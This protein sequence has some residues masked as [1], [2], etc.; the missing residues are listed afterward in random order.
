MARSAHPARRH[1][2][3]GAVAA[4][5]GIAAIGWVLAPNAVGFGSDHMAAHGV[6]E[7]A[8]QE[9]TPLRDGESLLPVSMARAYTPAKQNG[10]WDDYRCFILDPR[11]DADAWLTGTR[12]VPGNAAVVHHII[13]FQLDADRVAAAQEKDAAEPGAGWSCFGGPGLQVTT[14]PARSAFS[15]APW[16]AAWAPGGS[17]HVIPDG[18]GVRMAAGSRVI[19]QV[20]YNLRAGR[21]PD[22][23]RLELRTRPADHSMTALHT[24]LLAAPVELP[25]LPGEKGRLCDRSASIADTVKRF[26]YGALETISGLASVCR[27]TSPNPGPGQTQSCVWG[28][29]EDMIVYAAAPHMHLLGS[30]MTIESNPGTPRAQTLL[31]VPRY[32]FDRQGA[33]WLAQ[34]VLL[35]AGDALRITCTW[36]TALRRLL[37]AFAG[38]KPRY[39]TWGEGTTDEMCLGVLSASTVPAPSPAS[40]PR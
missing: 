8:A 34:P 2:A 39:V 24:R 3:V 7:Q 25:C 38:V 28:V 11:L 27:P 16:L 19:L 20:H 23:T 30:S 36:D 15:A 9:P 35:G 14:K 40:A 32:D 5:A 33:T 18:L 13:L 22:R 29:P 6:R 31:D 12:F 26:G 21:G 17:D 1:R 4:T 37:P 10:A